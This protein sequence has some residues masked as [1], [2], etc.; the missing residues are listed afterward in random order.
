MHAQ[1]DAA[2][3]VEAAS[4]RVEFNDDTAIETAVLEARG[5]RKRPLEDAQLMEKFR[6]LVRA[7][8]PGIDAQALLDQLWSLE[9]VTDVRSIIRLCVPAA[10]P[11]QP[12]Q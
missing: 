6:D 7:T 12:T 11:G 9:A 2:C 4:V 3:P 8:A 1:A 10:L 5:S